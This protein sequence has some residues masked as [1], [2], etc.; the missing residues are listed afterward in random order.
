[1]SER[2]LCLVGVDPDPATRQLLLTIGEQL[3][4]ACS[5]YGLAQEL[6]K[7]HDLSRPGCLVSELRL[8]DMSGLELQSTLCSRQSP[9]AIVFHS[10]I[11]D[12]AMT[13]AAMRSGARTVLVKPA[14]PVELAAAIKEAIAEGPGQHRLS[15]RAAE[16]FARFE[17]LTPK[18]VDVLLLML[19]GEPN[20]AIAKR[21]GIGLRTVEA[22][23]QN[24]FTKTG[25]DSLAELIRL[26]FEATHD[27]GDDSMRARRAQLAGLLRRSPRSSST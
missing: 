15:S 4:I 12:V 19:D 7:T 17:R 1:M 18:E 10:T 14:G 8:P 9:L 23:R 24:V 27:A 21:L 22:R 6:L 25:T 16:K 20:K 26:A 3:Q 11:A 2:S 5:V 13:V